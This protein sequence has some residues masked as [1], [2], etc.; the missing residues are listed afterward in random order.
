MSTI[1]PSAKKSNSFSL[2]W[3][4]FAIL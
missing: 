1:P 3:L 4:Y 2:R